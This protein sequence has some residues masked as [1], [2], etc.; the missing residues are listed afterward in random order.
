MSS[1]NEKNDSFPIQRS[2]LSVEDS[3]QRKKSSS[4]KEVDIG[5]SLSDYDFVGVEDDWL[6]LSRRSSAI[7]FSLPVFVVFSPCFI[8]LHP[9]R[10]HIYP[11]TSWVILR[12]MIYNLKY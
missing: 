7:S 5:F 10:P 6:S 2:M 4:D 12:T 1:F 11:F 3:S 9:Q 8:F